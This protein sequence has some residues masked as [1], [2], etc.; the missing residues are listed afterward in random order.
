MRGV[1]MEIADVFADLPVLETERTRLRRIRKEDEVDLFYYGSNPEVCQYTVWNTHQSIEDTREFINRVMDKY[2][3]QQ[4]A[5]WGI[6]DKQTGKFIGTSGFIYWDTHN[7]KAEL[8]Y[9]I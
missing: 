6:E 2:L 3:N 5:P 7:A 1:T 9:A 4:V 8:G